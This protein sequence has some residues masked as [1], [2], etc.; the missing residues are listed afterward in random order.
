MAKRKDATP[1]HSNLPADDEIVHL[2]AEP[3]K[4]NPAARTTAPISAEGTPPTSREPGD[5]AAT[6][7]SPEQRK[8][9][10][11]PRATIAVPLTEEAKRDH[12]KGEVA[13]YIDGYG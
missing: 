11:A 12:T 1:P 6:E 2:T 9:G 13:R 8:A 5:D 4:E 3:P 10:W 7:P